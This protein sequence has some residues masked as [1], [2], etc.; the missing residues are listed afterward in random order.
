MLEQNGQVTSKDVLDAAR[1][2]D[3]LAMH[4][5]DKVAF[6]LGLSTMRNSAN[7]LN[8]EKIVPGGGVSRAGEVLLA[9]VRDY[10]KRFAASRSA[11]C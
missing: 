4:V 9:P 3:E 8:P 2:K 10:F 11:R 6:H 7:A 5:V 1:S